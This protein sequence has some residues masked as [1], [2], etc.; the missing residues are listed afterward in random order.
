M[1]LVILESPFQ[2]GIAENVE[3]LRLAILDC[4]KRGES[5]YAS[6]RMLPGALNDLAPDEREIGIT[7]GFA[8]HNVAEYMVVYMDRGITPGMVRGIEHAQEIG[9]DVRHRYLVSVDTAIAALRAA[10]TGKA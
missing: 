8:W 10:P 7:A 1:K 2:G 3:Y 5:P 6:H 4:I 9:L